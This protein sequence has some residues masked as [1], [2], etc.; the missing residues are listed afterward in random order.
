MSLSL[1]PTLLSSLFLSLLSSLS[2]SLQGQ[3][4][5]ARSQIVARII[6]CNGDEHKMSLSAKLTK[7]HAHIWICFV[8][9][10][11]VTYYFLH[12]LSPLSE[13]DDA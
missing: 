10:S 8:Q 9:K 12:P 1:F 2:L 5:L 13:H 3:L 6:Q 11:S 4:R 7:N